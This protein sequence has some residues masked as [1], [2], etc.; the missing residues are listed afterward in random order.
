MITSVKVNAKK[1]YVFEA[2][3]LNSPDIAQQ[4][5]SLMKGIT[6]GFYMEIMTIFGDCILASLKEEIT[7]LMGLKVLPK[8]KNLYESFGYIISPKLGYLSF[9]STWDKASIYVPGRDSYKMTWL[10]KQKG[11]NRKIPMKDKNGDLVFRSVPLT[12]NKAWVHPGIQ[13]FSFFNR[14]IENGRWYA[15]SKVVDFLMLKDVL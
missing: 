2:P 14:A 3:T 6:A 5:P 10:T 15:A 1:Q 4:Y 7:R 12:T 9:Y 13:K 8:S 11:A